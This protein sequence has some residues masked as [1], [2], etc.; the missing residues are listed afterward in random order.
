MKDLKQRNILVQWE[1]KQRQY[2][3]A[4]EVVLKRSDRMGRLLRSDLGAYSSN[5]AATVRCYHR[6]SNTAHERREAAFGGECNG[7]F[8]WGMMH[9]SMLVWW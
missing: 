5:E 6:V 2:L 1:K 8:G 9:F 4:E 7:R 3:K